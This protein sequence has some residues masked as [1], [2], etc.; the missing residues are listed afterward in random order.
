MAETLDLLLFDANANVGF[1]VTLSSKFPHRL[2]A[3]SLFHTQ[4]L[5][6]NEPATALIYHQ[7]AIK[8]I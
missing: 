8:F 2:Q 7:K 3:H 1:P 5:Y 4:P 6:I